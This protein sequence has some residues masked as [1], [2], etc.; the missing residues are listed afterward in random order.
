MFEFF[1]YYMNAIKKFFKTKEGI[2]RSNN[3]SI[4][5]PPY[6]APFRYS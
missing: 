1:F 6:Y 2:P 4:V 5:C 3:T